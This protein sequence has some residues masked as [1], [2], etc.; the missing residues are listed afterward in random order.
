MQGRKQVFWKWS[1]SG[2]L[3]LVGTIVCALVLCKKH[4]KEFH[5]DVIRPSTDFSFQMVSNIPE[6]ELTHLRALFSQPFRFLNEGEQFFVFTSQDEEYVLKFFKI[7]RFTP[8]YWLNAIPLPWLDS[9]RIKKISERE[10]LR[11][12]TFGSFKIAFEEFRLQTGLLFLHLFRTEFLQL[13]VEVADQK[14][15]KHVIQLD[16][17]PFVLQ[18]KTTMFVDHL[19]QLLAQ[20]KDKEAISS[21]R[22]VLDLVKERSQRG[23]HVHLFG[24]H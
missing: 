11:Q 16:A 12:E 21:L 4:L 22:L 9:L 1:I 6:G 8:K 14:G 19:E 18:K 5:L 7:K 13:S 20:K 17:V 23:G 3:A 15:K 2:S 10:R 24:H